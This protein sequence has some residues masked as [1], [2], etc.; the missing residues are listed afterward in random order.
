[1][2][3]LTAVVF[4]LDGTLIDSAGDLLYAANQVLETFGCAPLSLREFRRMLGD[5][6]ATLISRA[7]AARACVVPEREALERFLEHYKTNLT[8]LTRPYAGAQVTLELLHTTGL[9]LA[10]CSNKPTD[11]A[12]VILERLGL[13]RYFTR[14][15][16]GD[17]LPFLKPDRR[18]LIEAVTALESA[19]ASSL[20][21]GDS[22]VD[23]STAIAAGVP[24][25]L[26]THGYHRGPVSD[27]P[28]LATLDTFQQL[29]EFL[30]R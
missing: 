2:R 17:S 5:G 8:R 7:L 10:V 14:V 4:D 18:V 26:M 25:V 9:K 3:R 1:V 6:V 29:G 28:S 16:G 21:V 12:R 30:A 11:L 13:D 23:A 22:E 20:F 19:P 15:L 27:I 24:F